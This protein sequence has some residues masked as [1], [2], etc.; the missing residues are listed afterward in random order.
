MRR[1]KKA[2]L[3][4]LYKPFVKRY[5]AKSRKYRYR[6][7]EIVVHPGVFHPGLFFSTKVLLHFIQS[8][9]LRDKT[10][11]ELGAGTGLI[12]ID[13]AKKGAKVTATDISEVAIKNIEENVRTNKVD[14]TIIHSDLFQNIP[15]QTFD[16]IMI[17]PPYYPKDP[18]TLEEHA[19]YCG[20]E[21][22]YFETLFG[23][24]NK[25]MHADS[26]AFMIL[27]EDVNIERIKSIAASYTIHLDEV[28]KRGLL[29][30]D[31]FIFRLEIG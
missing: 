23:N 11:L 30:E 1:I 26:K 28:H 25:F 14:V 24:V 31:N 27:S 13:A 9:Q 19:W 29:W 8:F 3:R 18:T 7:I 5:I 12:S 10:F 17:N 15:Q 2:I 4:R 21:Y 6:D 16:Y 22:Q 20:T